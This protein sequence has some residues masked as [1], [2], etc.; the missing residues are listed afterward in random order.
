MKEPQHPQ[1]LRVRY[2][3]GVFSQLECFYKVVMPLPSLF[4]LASLILVCPHSVL[5]LFFCFL[6]SSVPMQLYHERLFK[7]HDGNIEIRR[8]QADLDT[9]HHVSDMPQSN[10]KRLSL[11]QG[12]EQGLIWQRPKAAG[13]GAFKLLFFYYCGLWFTLDQRQVQDG[14]FCF[15]FSL[16]KCNLKGQ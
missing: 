11:Q 3:S 4:S 12:C 6:K 7:D 1:L 10:G 13:Q 15:L 5:L 14:R 2:I 16:L 8:Y 9:E